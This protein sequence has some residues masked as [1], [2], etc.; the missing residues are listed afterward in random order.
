MAVWLWIDDLEPPGKNDWITVSSFGPSK[1]RPYEEV[2]LTI[3]PGRFYARIVQ[4]SVRGTISDAFVFI[5][6][7]LEI[8]YHEALIS[9]FHTDR[10]TE[11]SDLL[12]HITLNFRKQTSSY[13]GGP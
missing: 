2:N 10:N 11:R 5:D 12:I 3:E 8:H 7:Q 13:A 4:R 9:S 1:S 6:P